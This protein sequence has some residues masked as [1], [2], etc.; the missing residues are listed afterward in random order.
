ELVE[1][2]ELGKYI[3][4]LRVMPDSSLIGTT[5]GEAKLGEEFGVYV[6]ELLRGDQKVWSPKAQTL[7]EGDIL[8]ARG[9]WSQLDELRKEA[10]LEVNAEFKLRQQSVE[11][12]EQVLTEVMIAPR[13]R[14]IGTTLGM[15]DPSWHHNT[16][17]LGI[18]R[19]GQVLRQE[20]RNVRLQV[21]DIL[22][23]LLPESEMSALR[24]DRN[25]VVLSER[26][27]EKS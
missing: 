27:A 13:S 10:G 25:I 1:H 21:G 3:T 7:Q 18:H 2:Y 19:R 15:L 23:M 12:V 5:V 14:L 26:P 20:L 4:E 16:T 17:S 24:K 6:L 22:L 8:L 11:E 9:D